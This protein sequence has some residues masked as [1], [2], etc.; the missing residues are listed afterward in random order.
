MSGPILLI[1]RLLMVLALYAFLGLVLVILWR[2]MKRQGELLSS[3]KVPIIKLMNLPKEKAR[4]FQFTIP[5]IL[6]GRD[7]SCEC[8]LNDDTVSANH[9]RLTFHH[10]KWWIEDLGSKNG[11]YLNQEHIP[12]PLVVTSG[13]Q[14]RFGQIVMQVTIDDKD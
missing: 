5:E 3:K 1:I 10:N 6:I 13:D 12:E 4:I 8:Q 2:D 7:P 14:L 11:T 9:A